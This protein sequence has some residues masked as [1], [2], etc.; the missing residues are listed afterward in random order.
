MSFGAPVTLE[1]LSQ[2]AKRHGVH[3]IQAGEWRV[4][5][6]ENAYQVFEEGGMVHAA[7]DD[8]EVQGVCEQIGSLKVKNDFLKKNQAASV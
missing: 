1:H 8:Q 3:P 5:L 7:N 6:L 4:K 2:I